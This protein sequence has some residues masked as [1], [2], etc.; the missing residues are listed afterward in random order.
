MAGYKAQMQRKYI[1]KKDLQGI[2]KERKAFNFCYFYF[3]Y[4]EG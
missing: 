1:Q 2:R 3:F 4:F